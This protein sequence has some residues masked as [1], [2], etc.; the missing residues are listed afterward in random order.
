MQA[1]TDSPARR[2]ADVVTGPVRL[3]AALTFVLLSILAATADH[4][5][6]TVDEPLS[7]TVR[8]TSQIGL[9]RAV[10]VSGE[11]GFTVP[12]AVVV[13]VCA[14]RRCRPLAVA[15]PVTLL[16][17][18]VVSNTL[19]HVTARPR[20][21]QPATEVSL[22]SFPSGHTLQATLLLGLLPLIVVLLANRRWLVDAAALVA[23]VGIAA[24]GYSRVYLGAHWPTD[25]VGSVLLGTGL[26]LAVEWLLTRRLETDQRSDRRPGEVRA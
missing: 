2:L 26:I 19:K 13:A 7:D 17:G 10:T 9:W 4:V 5:L 24:V 3:V 20:P 21:P 25:V 1:V 8:G 16:L 22:A 23:V 18:V 12:V 14:W 11:T 6:L 15:Y